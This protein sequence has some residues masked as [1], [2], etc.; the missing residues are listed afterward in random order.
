M[1]NENPYLLKTFKSI[2]LKHFNDNKKPLTFSFVNTLTF[3]KHKKLPVFLSTGT[4]N[5]KGISYRLS[6][7][8]SSDYKNNVFIIYDVPEFNGKNN[9]STNAISCYKV[10]QYPGF[11]CDLKKYNTLKEY[12]LD[13]ISK[14][15]RYK[16]NSYK[17]KLET[18]HDIHYKMYLDDITPETYENIF[19]HFNK[20]LKKR[21]SD[22]KIVNNNLD[23]EE[24]DFYKEVTLPLILNKQAGLFVVY[25]KDKPIAITLL[26]FSKDTVLDVIRVFDIDYKKLRLG[27]VSIMKQ[28]EWC[29][30][31]NYKAL[32][33]SKGY[34]E[35]KQRWANKPYW[36][37]YHIFYDKKSI[38][39]KAL[40]LFY[41][42]LFAFKLFVRKKHLT[43]Y[44]HQFKFFL[45]S[46][47]YAE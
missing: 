25:D 27:T 46:K 5:T 26:N 45:N 28:L 6:N 30:E 32:D 34:Y 8:I 33:F 7:N 13:V 47:R 2:W 37:E 43:D 16:F 15:S 29:I 31:N 18:S 22:K 1:N 38:K 36:F 3:I 19:N 24:W 9:T 4:T 11:I 40:A 23:P 17:R 39:A 41:K 44:I 35:Y 14:K 10:K 20:L 42:N 21:F 12:M